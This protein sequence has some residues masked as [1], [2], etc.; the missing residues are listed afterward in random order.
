MLQAWISE[1]RLTGSFDIVCLRG[2]TTDALQLLE[3]SKGRRR[4]PDGSFVVIDASAVVTHALKASTSAHG[5]AA[6]GD[7]HPVRELFSG[8]DVK[9][10]YLG[11]EADP[12]VRAEALSR[13]NAM[14]D[15]GERFG[16]H[17]GRLFPGLA[18]CP[19]LEVPGWA[20]LP[21]A[22]GCAA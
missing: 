9:L 2:T 13:F 12:A 3:Y 14:A 11:T 10:V 6:A 21:L 8:G 15:H 16:L 19:H 20:E 22:V 1:W 7:F 18:D 17:S 5:H 4:L